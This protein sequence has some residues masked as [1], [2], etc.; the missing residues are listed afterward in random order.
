MLVADTGRKLVMPLAD[1]ESDLLLPTPESCDG[2]CDGMILLGRDAG[3][4]DDMRSD[5]NCCWFGCCD[6]PSSEGDGDNENESDGG[7][8]ASTSGACAANGDLLLWLLPGRLVDA[9]AKRC[10]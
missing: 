5:G 10:G 2:E 6:S 8:G 9:R 4:D 1:L 7:R 3:R